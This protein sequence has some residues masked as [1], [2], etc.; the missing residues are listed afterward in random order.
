MV[1]ARMEFDVSATWASVGPEVD[2][3]EQATRQ[4]PVLLF[5]YVL[6]FCLDCMPCARGCHM[7]GSVYIPSRYDV[8][9]LSTTPNGV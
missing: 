9:L 1:L 7:L 2:A 4:G 3:L 6:S 5:L 8:T